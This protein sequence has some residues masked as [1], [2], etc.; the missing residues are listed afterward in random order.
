MKMLKEMVRSAAISVMMS[1]TIF[2]IVG[3][4]FDQVGK[5]SFS[6][7]NYGFTKMMIACLVTGL[8]FGVPSVLYHVEN[9]PVAVAAVI[10]L[11]IGLAVYFFAA[12]K[13][14]WIPTSAGTVAC[15]CTIVGMIL[16]TLLIWVCFMAYYK[17]LA[18][19]MNRELQ[20]RNLKGM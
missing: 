2:G 10:H 8:A 16:V 11:G 19:R 3:V 12:A 15:V 7:D 1:M 6:L 5:G 4:V 17:S 20:A 18:E 13:V 14:G 9:V